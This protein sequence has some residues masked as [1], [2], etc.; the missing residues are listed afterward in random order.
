MIAKDSQTIKNSYRFS[1]AP[2]L[3]CTDRHFRVLMRQITKRALLYTE[4][5]VAQAIHHSTKRNL[6]L[7]FDAIEHPISLQLAGDNP[8]LL[9]EAAKFGESWGYDEINLN[10]GCPSKKVQ[11][12]NFG[13]CLMAKPDQVANCVEAMVEA[14]TLPIT[15]KHRIGIDNLDSDSFL[16]NFVDKVS[17]AGAARFSIH[18]RKAWLNGLNPH[19][20]RTI[21]LLNYE[22]VFD[23]KRSRP[24]LIIELNGGL[25]TPKDCIK[26]L[27]KVD[28][29]MVGRSAYR[30]PLLWQKIDELIYEEKTEPIKPS[31]VIEGLIPY[32]EK[33]IGNG[34]RL[35]EIVRHTLK[36]IQNIPGAKSLR[37]EI[38]E[39][40]HKN[41]SDIKVFFKAIETLENSGL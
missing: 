13:A 38:S 23:L 8:R 5:I 24:E 30:N 19:E 41:Q 4:M 9:A 6:L 3:D 29:V 22:K 32:A 33:H 36:L 25:E 17:S 2:M 10:I 37:H 11:S 15:I 39:Q 12:G 7:D 40:T 21:P 20:N 34:G 28:G 18:A 26:A 31:K 16:R 27:E 1:V 35:W 14:T